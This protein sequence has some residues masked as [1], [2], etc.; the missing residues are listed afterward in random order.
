MS[1]WRRIERGMRVLM[2]R[3]AADRDIDEE[4]RHYLE[5]TIAAF[6][7]R[8]FSPD[9]ARRAARLEFGSFTA[10]REQV[11]EGGWENALANAFADCRHAG[12]RLARSPGLAVTAIVTL[13]LGIGATTTILP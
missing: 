3:A 9:E 1:L 13:A 5:E 12:R 2:N 7:H 11:R 10:V 6:E 4:A 8:G